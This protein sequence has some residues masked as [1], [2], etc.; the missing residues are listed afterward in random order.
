MNL[1]KQDIYELEKSEYLEINKIVVKT[2]N[3]TNCD[4]TNLEITKEALLQ[5][6]VNRYGQAR[7]PDTEILSDGN[8]V[9]SDEFEYNLGSVLVMAKIVVQRSTTKFEYIHIKV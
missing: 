5:I 2:I 4:L 8:A 1:I 6:L 3:L 7:I 9:F